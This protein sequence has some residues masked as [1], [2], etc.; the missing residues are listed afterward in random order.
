MGFPLKF[1][2][3]FALGLTARAM[4]ARGRRPSVLKL[5]PFSDVDVTANVLPAV[6]SM[7]R[8]VWIGGAEPLE[9]PGIARHVNE[10][11]ASGREVFLQTSGEM[12]HRRIHEFQP[13]PRFRFVF[14]FDGP[15]ARRNS[16]AV[17]AIRVARLSGFLVC[18]LTVLRACGEVEMLAKLH[19]ELHQIDLDGYLIVPGAHGPEL[20][21][22][23]GDAKHRLLNRRWRRLSGMFDSVLSP[24]HSH[25]SEPAAQRMPHHSGA[26][27]VR[28]GSEN[29]ARDCGEGAQA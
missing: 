21:T 6:E 22:I 8:I 11:A 3:D 5:A 16:V 15:S 2:S 28:L 12:L 19:A 29:S 9:H 24:A 1:T 25:A 20:K 13:S 18:A 26:A 17:E 4:R 27:I 10:L 7:T 14:R 23:L